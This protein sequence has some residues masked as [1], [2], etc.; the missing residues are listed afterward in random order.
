MLQAVVLALQAVVL[1]LQAVVAS[2][3]LV[4]ALASR[5]LPAKPFEVGAQIRNLLLLGECYA[6]VHVQVKLLTPHA[7]PG[8]RRRQR[9]ERV[10]FLRDGH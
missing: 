5:Q 7:E 4:V 9:L 2:P 6:K 3:G 10:T 1:A 8:N